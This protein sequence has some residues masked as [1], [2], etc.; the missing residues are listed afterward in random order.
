TTE[1]DNERWGQHPE[2]LVK[3]SLPGVHLAF[4]NPRELVRA[5]VRTALDDVVEVDL[6][7][8]PADP[9]EQ[10]LQEL[11]RRPNEGSPLSRLLLTPCLTDEHD[12][13]I[14][15]SLSRNAASQ[16]GDGHSPRRK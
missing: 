11:P 8:P 4:G 14:S 5:R 16:R 10:L 12:S 2:P 7:P 9:L 1:A 13:C 3:V 15:R 6:A